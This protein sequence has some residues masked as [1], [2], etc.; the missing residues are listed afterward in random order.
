MLNPNNVSIDAN[1][2]DAEIA[3]AGATYTPD[4]TF[5]TTESASA[6]TSSPS[7][8][9]SS[10]HSGLSTGAK[11][12]IGAG[13]AVLLAIF[14]GIC[15]F[16]R[17][18]RQTRREFGENTPKFQYPPSSSYP[19]K[20]LEVSISHEELVSHAAKPARG[21]IKHLTPSVSLYSLNRE[22]KETSI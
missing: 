9:P 18:R 19:L 17:Q 6:P 8:I 22:V 2:N 13:L 10:H 7:A 16:M 3:F 4:F 1:A 12:G 20:D 15:M 21:P 14:I 11:A 5:P